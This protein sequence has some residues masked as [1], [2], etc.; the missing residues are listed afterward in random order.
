[1]SRHWT[2][3]EFKGGSEFFVTDLWNQWIEAYRKVKYNETNWISD[4][5][6]RFSP[7][8]KIGAYATY[9]KVPFMA[10][11]NKIGVIAVDIS[12]SSTTPLKQ[13][14]LSAYDPD[15]GAELAYTRTEA[16]SSTSKLLSKTYSGK[17]QYLS[18]TYCVLTFTPSTTYINDSGFPIK[19]RINLRVQINDSSWKDLGVVGYKTFLKFF[20]IGVDSLTGCNVLPYTNEVI[21]NYFSNG[22]FSLAT[23]DLYD[24]STGLRYLNYIIPSSDDIVETTECWVSVKCGHDSLLSYIMKM[25]NSV[26]Y[27]E[28]TNYYQAMKAIT[29]G[30]SGTAITNAKQIYDINGEEHDDVYKYDL[31]VSYTNWKEYPLVGWESLSGVFQP[32]DDVKLKRLAIQTDDVSRIINISSGSMLPGFEETATNDIFELCLPMSTQAHRQPI[33]NVSMSIIANTFKLPFWKYKTIDE[34]IML[35]GAE[36]NGAGGCTQTYSVRKNPGYFTMIMELSDTGSC[37]IVNNT[38]GLYIKFYV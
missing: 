3:S 22:F 13:I 38:L 33:D 9:S 12:K 8:P 32:N 5:E 23:G 26:S 25:N 34:V 19:K 31:K 20:E 2:T 29:T 7:T 37:D 36:F 15:T 1:M 17:K 10:T 18:Y 14:R 4:V 27:K 24:E 30:L 35:K 11:T 6:G 21:P 28:G 16:I